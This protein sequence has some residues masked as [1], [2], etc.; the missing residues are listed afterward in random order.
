MERWGLEEKPSV[1]GD[2][3][4]GSEEMVKYIQQWGSTST[5]SISINQKPFLWSV[6]QSNLPP[7]HWN[8]A[9]IRDSQVYACSHCLISSTNS[10][11]NQQIFTNMVAGFE[12]EDTDDDSRESEEESDTEDDSSS[13][14]PNYSIETLEKLTVK[15]LREISKQ[16]NIKQGKRKADLIEKILKR[17]SSIHENRSGLKRF[18]RSAEDS[19]F[20]DP[21]PIHTLYG[22]HFNSVDLADKYWYNVNDGHRNEQW[23][24]HLFLGL[25][26]FQILN[27]WVMGNSAM[28]ESWTTFRENLSKE[29][30]TNNF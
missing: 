12:E 16:F 25:M 18:I 9:V 28:P 14:I 15:A 2:A 24:S 1:I 22:D 8:Y 3:A 26:R 20:S 29:M 13:I 4:F 27:S 23:K 10:F 5:F 17:V 21:S 30:R 19:T 11:I 7:N 6:L